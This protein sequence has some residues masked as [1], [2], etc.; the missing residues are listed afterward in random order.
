M[1]ISRTENTS[2]RYE[3]RHDVCSSTL[4]DGFAGQETHLGY[5]YFCPNP[6][7]GLNVRT[8][9]GKAC[10]LNKVRQPAR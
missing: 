4:F 1:Y 8:H 3:T 2:Q 6:L 5:F 7:T 10:A 9:V